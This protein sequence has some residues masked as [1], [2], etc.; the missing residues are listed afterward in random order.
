MI[1]TNDMKCNADITVNSL[2]IRERETQRERYK[3]N[4]MHAPRLYSQGFPM[5]TESEQ[6]NDDIVTGLLAVALARYSI[7]SEADKQNSIAQQFSNE[8]CR[9]VRM[10]GDEV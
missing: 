6:L 3:K 8:V 2:P 9:W 5:W 7:G 1:A 4:I 10:Y